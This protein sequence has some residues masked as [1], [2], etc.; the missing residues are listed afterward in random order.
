MERTQSKIGAAL[1]CEAYITADHVDN[2]IA[3][4]HFFN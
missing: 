1:L 3:R 2:V 4:T